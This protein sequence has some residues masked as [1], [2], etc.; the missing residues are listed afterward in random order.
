LW[1]DDY[2]IGQ[3]P[4]TP[5]LLGVLGYTTGIEANDTT[6]SSTFPYVQQPWSG[7]GLCAGNSIVT[8]INPGAELNIGA[9]PVM[10]EAFPNP[11]K[12]QSNF[13]IRVA[14]KASIKLTIYDG[15]SR[16]VATPL[17]NV[18]KEKGTTEVSLNTSKFSNGVYY[19]VLANNNQTV[20]S[21]KFV[22]NK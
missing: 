17:N 11:A 22:I 15:E 19:A 8:A 12:T 9:P 6:F 7:Y 4:L 1:Y 20:Q 3:S 18:V 13:R 16:I 5:N 10:M 21:I 2:T 14:N